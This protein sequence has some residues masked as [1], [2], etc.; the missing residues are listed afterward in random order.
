MST[1]EFFYPVKNNRYRVID[2]DTVE[3]TLDRGWNDTKLTALRIL[4]ID[5]P[6]SNTRRDLLEREAGQLVT[7]VVEAWFAKQT[8]QLYASSEKKPKFFGRTIGR[9]WA[10]TIDNEISAYLSEKGLVADYHGGTKVP[11]TKEKLELIIESA[12]LL[13]EG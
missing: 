10:G 4:G 3:V 6:E 13:L 12:R 9:I 2:G 7:K 5:T 1:P 11:W 8:A